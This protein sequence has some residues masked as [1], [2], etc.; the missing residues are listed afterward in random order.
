VRRE[1]V[2]VVV[3]QMILIA[4]AGLTGSTLAVLAVIGMV[5]FDWIA[6]GP[7]D[8]TAEDDPGE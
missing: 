5:S 6:R 3:I 1:D 7:Y 2:P 8:E 4:L